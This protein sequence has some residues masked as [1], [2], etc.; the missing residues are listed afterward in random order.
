MELDSGQF[1]LAEGRAA[2]ARAAKPA[3]I[4]KRNARSLESALDAGARPELDALARSHVAAQVSL[5]DELIDHDDTLYE[6][7]RADSQPSPRVDATNQRAEH[8]GRSAE[9]Q[10]TFEGSAVLDCDRLRG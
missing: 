6:S 4:A 7:I 3:A 10:Q 5:D 2:A 8:T 1:D 9:G